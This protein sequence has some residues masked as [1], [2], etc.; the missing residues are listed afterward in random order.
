MSDWIGRT[1]WRSGITQRKKALSVTKDSDFHEFSLIYG[2]PPKIIW[3]KC[4]NKLKRYVLGLLLNNQ[5]TVEAFF[6]DQEST[7]LEI[8]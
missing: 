1:I 3:L 4:G 7:R 6:E 8:Y 5:K 2:N